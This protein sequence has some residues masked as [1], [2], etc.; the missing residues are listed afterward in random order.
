MRE[1][2]IRKNVD[3][4]GMAVTHL[5]S[6]KE[7]LVEVGL[8]NFHHFLSESFRKLSGNFPETFRKYWKY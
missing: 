7:S 3:E 6:L 8:E 5:W 4:Y 1:E 2:A